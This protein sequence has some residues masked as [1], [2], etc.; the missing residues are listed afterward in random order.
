[1]SRRVACLWDNSEKLQSNVD[2]H[3]LE[4]KIL[5]IEIDRSSS[6]SMNLD[7]G[8]EPHHLNRPGEV[9][10]AAVLNLPTACVSY[11]PLEGS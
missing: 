1:M 2:G 5:A 8:H 6:P 9:L 3:M 10:Q 7:L 11:R 4:R